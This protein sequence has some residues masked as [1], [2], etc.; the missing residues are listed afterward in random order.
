MSPTDD[1][2]ERPSLLSQLVEGRDASAV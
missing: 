2:A 1:D